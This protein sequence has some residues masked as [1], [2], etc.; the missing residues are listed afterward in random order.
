MR[1]RCLPSHKLKPSQPAMIGTP[2][3]LTPVMS[4]V[5]Q[6]GVKHGIHFLPGVSPSFRRCR[7]VPISSGSSTASYG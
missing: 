2:I 1:A 3:K 5:E 4:F 7:F 6:I